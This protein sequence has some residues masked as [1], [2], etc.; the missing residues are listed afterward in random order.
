MRIEYIVELF[1]VP[2]YSTPMRYLDLP[3]LQTTP[4]GVDYIG[5]EYSGG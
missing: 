5:E 2:R 4:N 3:N 1:N